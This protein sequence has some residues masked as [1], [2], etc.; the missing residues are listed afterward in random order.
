MY[1]V[2]ANTKPLLAREQDICSTITFSLLLRFY[3]M[4]QEPSR[5][6][7]QWVGLSFMPRVSERERKK[8]R[9][10]ERKREDAMRIMWYMA[11]NLSMPVPTCCFPKT[12]CVLACRL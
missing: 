10:R 9:K 11:V 3:S 1:S 12:P 6:L 2:G 7:M 4:R 8:E 5:A